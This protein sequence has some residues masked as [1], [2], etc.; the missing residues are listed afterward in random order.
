MGVFRYDRSGIKAI[1]T[2]DGQIRAPA[3][4][5]R[6]GVFVYLTADGRQIREL[7]LPS[8]V[9]APEALASFE[10]APV[11][12]DHPVEN[13][14]AVTGDNAR[15]LTVGAVSQVRQD[16]ELSDH[17][18]AMIAIYDRS[19]AERV[20]SG[21]QE[22]SCGYFCDR[23]PAQP[24]AVWKD[25]DGKEH[26]YDFIQRNIRGN[27]VAIV[28]RA[29]AGPTARILLNDSADAAVMQDP[30]QAPRAEERQHTMK[31]ITINGVTYEVSE[32][33]SQAWAKTQADFAKSVSAAHAERDQAT[34]R[35]DAAERESAKLRDALS[36]A[37]SP[38][39]IAAAVRERVDLESKARALSVKTD[40]LSNDQIRSAVIAKIDPSLNLDGK[41]ND[42]VIGLFSALTSESVIAKL[43]TTAPVKSDSIKTDSP[44]DPVAMREKH[45]A[46]FFAAATVK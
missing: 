3:R 35:A 39:S 19:T 24:G 20:E 1:R 31:S 9:F 8:E 5:T 40:G 13:A 17:V 10:L 7:R 29:R 36:K 43:G 28:D 16:S 6:T 45:R 42:Y 44:T 26:P 30:T 11:V 4:L 38:D 41:S 21:K 33:V 23:E 32:Q 46:E 25:S 37:T 15:R 14:G 18:S 27:H 34:A 2:D 12:D 22:L